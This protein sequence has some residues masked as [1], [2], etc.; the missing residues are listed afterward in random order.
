MALLGISHPVWLYLYGIEQ[1]KVPSESLPTD[2]MFVFLSEHPLSI[3]HRIWGPYN[4]LGTAL[5]AVYSGRDSIMPFHI[6]HG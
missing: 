2:C 3:E 6:Y 5:Y 1:R 4:F